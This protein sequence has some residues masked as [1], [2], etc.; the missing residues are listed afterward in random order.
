MRETTL[1]I[2]QISTFLNDITL[3]YKFRSYLVEFTTQ[4]ALQV[5]TK[6]LEIINYLNETT[7]FFTSS[8]DLELS[9][10]EMFQILKDR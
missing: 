2:L 8:Q 3:F 5:S 7:I 10:Q 4:T 1:V 6:I 9:F